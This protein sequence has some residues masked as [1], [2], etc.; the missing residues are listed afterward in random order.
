M[1]LKAKSMRRYEIASETGIA[2]HRAVEE[3]PFE[4]LRSRLDHIEAVLQDLDLRVRSLLDVGRARVRSQPTHASVPLCLGDLRVD[5]GAHR[6]TVA[7]VDVS[8]T[9]VEF[10]LLAALIRHHGAVVSRG[11]LLVE[12]WGR[13]EDTRTRTVDTHVKRLR[14]QL[15]SVRTYIQTVRGLGYRFSESPCVRRVRSVSS[16]LHALTQ[17]RPNGAR[18]PAPS[19][20]GTAPRAGG[21]GT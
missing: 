19:S 20:R 1:D 6:V 4:A 12:V 14:D 18:S 2:F 13:S 16:E 17:R 5:F 11:T 8:L 3:D 7:S 21:A 15:G 10:K 9:T